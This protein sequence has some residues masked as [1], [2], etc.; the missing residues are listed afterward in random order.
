L[1]EAAITFFD[2]QGGTLIDDYL[3]ET[4]EVE[5]AYN[6][7][8]APALGNVAKVPLIGSASI[9]PKGTSSTE[10]VANV[11]VAP[12]LGRVEFTQITAQSDI[13]SFK[14]AGVYVNNYYADLGLN[15]YKTGYSLVNHSTNATYYATTGIDEKY[16]G[17]PWIFDEGT[18]A[19]DGGVAKFEKSVGS[20]EVLAYNLLAPQLGPSDH[21][22]PHLVIKVTDVKDAE[23]EPWVHGSG[24]DKDIWWLTLTN[25]VPKGTLN[26]TDDLY[27]KFEAGKVY[28]IG[29]L[30]F[31]LGDLTTVPELENK[32]VFV[33]V[34]VKT[35]VPVLV[36]PI[37]GN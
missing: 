14:V 8:N 9:T 26:V 21:Y 24:A 7:A 28:Q 11:D 17:K 33:S 2:L 15:G 10:F 31:G 4:Y 6:S 1:P 19:S 23:D 22:F 16:N 18:W 5:K 37:L 35:W 32:I 36:D 27:I 34:E 13:T 25:V 29:N 30:S 12:A 20:K 3:K